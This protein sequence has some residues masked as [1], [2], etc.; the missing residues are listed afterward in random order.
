MAGTE[1][2]R[3]LEVVNAMDRAGLE[4][5]IMNYY[6]EFDRDRVQLDF[7][8]HRGWRGDYEDEIESLGGRIYRAPRLYPQHCLS[9]RRFM[10]R[11]FAERPY[12]VVHSHI[13]AMSAFPLA[14]ARDCGVPVRIAHSHSESIDRDVKLPIKMAARRNLPNVATHYWACSKS[15]GLFLFGEKNLD[16]VHVVRNAVDLEAYRFDSGARESVRREL[17]I[18]DGQLAVGHVGRFSKVKNHAHLINLLVELRA[19]GVDAV[20]VLCGGGELH[21]D[22]QNMVRKS[23]LDAYVRFLGVRDDV[24]RIVNAFDVF[25]FPSLYEGISL[26]LIEAQANGLP[27]LASDAV[28]GE[29][30]MLPTAESMSLELP[31]GDWAEA[32]IRLSCGGRAEGT[33]EVLTDAGYEIHRAAKELAEAYF[34]LYGAALLDGGRTCV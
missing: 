29:S 3:I 21:D 30:L 2:I 18:A 6:R 8:V 32:A 23:G 25:V 1:P 13:D 19:R 12:P 5:M 22:L 17:D 7:L 31:I 16:K 9:Y 26:A 28:S 24:P 10:R 27:V 33:I 4:T 20:L 34:A 11:F 14:M 15:A